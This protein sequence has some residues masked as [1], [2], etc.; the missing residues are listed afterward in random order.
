MPLHLPYIPLLRRIGTLADGLGLTAFAVGGIVRD[1]LLKRPTGDLDFVTLGPGSGIQLAMTVAEH[2]N[3]EP[4]NVFPNFGTA[5]VR[6]PAGPDHPTLALE[7]VGARKESY[8]RGSRKPIVETGTLKDDQRRRDFTIN[9]MAVALNGETFGTLLDPFDGQADLAEGLLRTPLAPETTF[10]DD[11]LRMMRAARFATQLGFRIEPGTFRAMR[12]QARRINIVSQE[13]ITEELRKMVRA[14]TPSIGFKMLY[15]TGLLKHIFPD[16]VALAGVDTVDGYRHKDNFYHTLQVLDN[17]A[18]ATTDRPGEDTEWLRWAALL[19]DIAKP[20]TK[21]FT[22]GAGW[23][24]HGHEDLGNRMVPRIFRALRLPNDERM[25]LVRLLVR[26]HHRPVA[27]VDEEVTD[28]AVRRLLFDAGD[29]IDDLMT[30]VRAD[31][32]SKNPKRVQRYLGHFD[33]VEAKM[34]E[35]EEKDRLRNFQPPVDGHEIMTVLGLTEGIAVGIIK[36]NIREAILEGE[37]PNEHDPAFAYMMQIKDDALRRAALFDEIIPTLQGRERAAIPA[38][39]ETL[40]AGALPEDPEAA[41][42]HLRRIVADV[43]QPSDTE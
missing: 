34:A 30:L 28:A 3:T 22:R 17:L 10:S 36:E 41:R 12:A 39:K 43:T 42:A 20:Q 23:S 31:I 37:I 40:F 38:L 29:A 32:T 5:A 24:F 2:L 6:V 16:L 18:H 15:T 33:L 25:H 27:L 7:F 4:A 26:L 11:P 21:R 35:V 14:G 8:R 1:A 13:R 9:A 19:H